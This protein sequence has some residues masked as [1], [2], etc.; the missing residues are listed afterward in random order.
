MSVLFLTG[1]IS[2]ETATGL[3]NALWQCVADGKPE[4]TLAIDC[5]GGMVT[6][7]LA[8]IK[9]MQALPIPVNT[10]CVS[11]AFS[12][13]AYLLAA[14]TSGRRFVGAEANVMVH[15]IRVNNFSGTPEELRQHADVLER[16]QGELIDRFVRLSQ[17]RK[18]RDEWQALIGD[19]RDHEMSPQQVVE[20]GLADKVI[21]KADFLLA[22]RA[23][24]V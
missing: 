5:F 8:I 2:E 12:M 1:G 17:G 23:T 15:Y 14:G 20:W 4:V 6:A 10:V 13:A 16:E 22:S 24:A 19:Y 3:Q 11:R 18:S 7:S 9:T 21:E